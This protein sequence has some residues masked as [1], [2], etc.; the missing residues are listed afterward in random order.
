MN[1]VVP[2]IVAILS[3]EKFIGFITELLSRASKKP[4]NEMDQE[5]VDSQ[6]RSL[7]IRMRNEKSRLGDN[8]FLPEAEVEAVKRARP[9]VRTKRP[10]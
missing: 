3:N 6:E 1:A 10:G 5:Y 2:I 8:I 7:Q 4:D 9:A